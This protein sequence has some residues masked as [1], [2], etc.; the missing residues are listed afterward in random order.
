MSEKIEEENNL[1]QKFMQFGIRVLFGGGGMGKESQESGLW[2]G[3]RGETICL[4]F[5]RSGNIFS[6][7]EPRS[8]LQLS[9]CKLY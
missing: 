1:L 3:S 8:R 4:L 7:L 6:S 9:L 5:G 2:L